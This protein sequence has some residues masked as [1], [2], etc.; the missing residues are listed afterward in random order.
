MNKWKE[1]EEKHDRALKRQQAP[2]SEEPTEKKPRKEV[3]PGRV[4]VLYHI[5]GEICYITRDLPPEADRYDYNPGKEGDIPRGKTWVTF[6]ADGNELNDFD[7]SRNKWCGK[8]IR[9]IK[10]DVIE[11]ARN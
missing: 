1:M 11:D 7:K 8:G 6:D 2:S 3:P 4:Y 10:N 5:N 9:L